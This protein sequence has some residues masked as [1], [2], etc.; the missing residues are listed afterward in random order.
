MVPSATAAPNSVNPDGTLKDTSDKVDT[1]RRRRP[2]FEQFKG[3]VAHSGAGVHAPWDETSGKVE[4]EFAWL[5]PEAES[6]KRLQYPDSVG[7][8]VE[9][10]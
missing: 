4:Q 7:I 8:G 5:F 2:L 9:V 3:R 1:G 10:R 6:R